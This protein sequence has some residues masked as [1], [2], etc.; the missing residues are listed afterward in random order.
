MTFESRAASLRWLAVT[1]FVLSS[2]LNY[3]DRQILSV[4]AP[5]IVAQFHTNLTNFGWLL[6]LF[7]ISYAAAALFA[8]WFLDRA[9]VNRA[10]SAAVAWWSLAAVASGLAP[11]FAWLG[12]SR[13]ALG[14]GESAGV[15]A[16]GKL[17]GIYLKPEERALGAAVNQVGLSFGSALI[18]LWVA[19]AGV[20]SW[21]VPFLCAGLLGW[22]WIPLWRVVNRW[23]PPACGEIDAP[24]PKAQRSSWSALRD[25]RLI[26]LVAANVLWM[27]SYSLWSN[28]SFIY[29]T[30][31]YHVSLKEA[32]SYLWIP[33]LVSNIGGFFGG[34]LS[35]AWMRRNQSAVSSRRRAVWVSTFGGL[36]GLL[37]PLTTHPGWGTVLISTSFF[38]AL[39]GSVN[40]YA[41]PIDIFGASRAG[42]AIAALTCAFG[43]LQ[44]VTSPIIGWLSDHHLY[45]QVIWIATAPLLLSAAILQLLPAKQQTLR[46]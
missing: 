32:A 37:L 45:T 42:F 26:I 15:P 5:Q 4:F 34:W 18:P 2:T 8:G 33:P 39:A 11:T 19:L 12:V 9:G 41:L 25:R 28:W 13:A 22:L 30:R 46:T 3:L 43:I 21:R 14:I 7:S 23:I 38:F 16:V 29:Y 24:A 35:L 40:I 1:I 10:I 31:V 36:L 27:G 17:N 6:S 20:T 44:T